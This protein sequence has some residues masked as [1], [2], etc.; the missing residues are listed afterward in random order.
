MGAGVV[1]QLHF[2]AVGAMG[3]RRR[4]QMIVSAPLA[5]AHLGVTPFRVCHDRASSA[6][7]FLFAPPRGGGRQASTVRSRSVISVFLEPFELET[8]E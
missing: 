3:I 7:I 2:V 5:A 6:V 4:R 8:L 1:G